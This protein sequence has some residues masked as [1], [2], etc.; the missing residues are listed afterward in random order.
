[1][2]TSRP[3]GIMR[4]LVVKGAN[5][6]TRELRKALLE[7][8]LELD[9]VS[10]PTEAEARARSTNYDAVVLDLMVVLSAREG[11]KATLEEGVLTK[12]ADVEALLAKLMPLVKRTPA[13]P[14]QAVA[15]L[16]AHDL[17]IN[18]AGRTV[19]R[20]GNPIHLTGREFEVLELLAR[21]KGKLV[22]HSAIRASVWGGESMHQSIIGTYI[23]RVRD[24]VDKGHPVE[25]IITRWGRGYMLRGDG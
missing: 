17:E 3:E 16:R 23:G 19:Q 13:V 8:G 21:H 15:V 6:L 10:S 22:S 2:N 18:T 24:K 7:P 5:P 11:S 20:A 14:P 9:L 12:P 1:V 4:I 25:L